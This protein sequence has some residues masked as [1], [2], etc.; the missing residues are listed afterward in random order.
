MDAVTEKENLVGL[1][2]DDANFVAKAKA[3][4]KKLHREIY[5]CL[6]VI[7]ELESACDILSEDEKRNFSE[8]RENWARWYAEDL[9]PE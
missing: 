2:G 1:T 3:F 9:K 6:N 7:C 8:L 4:S 5:R